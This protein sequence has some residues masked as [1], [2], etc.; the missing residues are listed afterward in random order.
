[1]VR[2]RS[3]QALQPSYRKDG[4]FMIK[5][6]KSGREFN[7]LSPEKRSILENGVNNVILDLE[8]TLTGSEAMNFWAAM[9]G[10]EK[11]VGGITNKAMNN[12]NGIDEREYERSLIAR[13]AIN[14]ASGPMIGAA[15]QENIRLMSSNAVEIVNALTDSGI[16]VLVVTGGMDKVADSISR[17]FRCPFYTNRLY[18]NSITGRYTE[19]GD[20]DVLVRTNGKRELVKELR[21]KGIIDGPV[22]VFGDGTSDM[23]VE[24]D[25]KICM[26]G[27]SKRTEAILES[28]IAVE[29][30]EAILPVFEGRNRRKIMDRGY[31][32]HLLRLGVFQLKSPATQFNDLA[33]G[34][35]L[36]ADLSEEYNPKRDNDR[37]IYQFRS[38]GY[39]K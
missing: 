4:F 6:E 38:N 10:A 21:E 26:A 22:G 11:E 34:M 39:E 36:L 35:Q 24:A 9:I 5:I 37:V 31:Y 12:R 23:G 30:I 14:Q 15:G 25:I 17:Y 2:L 29:A 33:F 20:Q 28:D 16:N 32:Q 19:I 1:M 27:W 8:S 3:P 7:L 18:K 13:L